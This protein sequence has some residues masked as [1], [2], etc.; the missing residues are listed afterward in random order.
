MQTL[1]SFFQNINPQPAPKKSSLI[2]NVAKG[3]GLA[4]LGAG[5]IYGARL[6]IK[7]IKAGIHAGKGATLGTR[8]NAGLN[9]AKKTMSRDIANPNRLNP[10]YKAPQMQKMSKAQKNLNKTMKIANERLM[11]WS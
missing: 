5:G 6:G 9:S 8:L 11:D 10:F 3:V 4:S 1:S 7:G 2:G